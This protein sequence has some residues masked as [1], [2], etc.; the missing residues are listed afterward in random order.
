MVMRPISMDEIDQKR[1]QCRNPLRA[2]WERQTQSDSRGPLDEIL[3][4]HHAKRS[5]QRNGGSNGHGSESVTQAASADSPGLKRKLREEEVLRDANE[6]AD[7]YNKRR[8]VGVVDRED[9][10]IFGLRK[11]NNWIK[12]VMIGQFARGRDPSLDGRARP[13]RGRILDL[14][15]GKGGDLKKWDKVD[16]SALVGVDIASLSIEQAKQRHQDGRSR[17]EAHFFA[18]DCFSNTLAEGIPRPLLEPMFDSVSL[19]FC[20]HYAWENV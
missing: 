7:H 2:D 10:P 11:F 13:R 17:W 15:C 12:S 20:M 6:V 19:Q 3:A 14:G 8:E 5:Q 16:P 4:E 1:R 9:S 18:F